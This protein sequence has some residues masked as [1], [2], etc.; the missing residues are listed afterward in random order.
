MDGG[1]LCG[2]GGSGSTVWSRGYGAPGAQAATAVTVD[3]SGKIV[4]VGAINGSIDF[5]CGALMST[6]SSSVFV[7]K[8][9]PSAG[10]VWSKRFDST[11]GSAAA[12][13]AVDASDDILIA[14]SFSGSIDLGGTML[15]GKGTNA[16]VTKLDPSGTP[17]WSESFGNGTAV[18][19]G[20][21]ADGTGNILVIG[22]FEGSIDLG[23][24]TLDGGGS[25]F[26]AKLDPNGVPM[27]G[28]SSGPTGVADASGVAVDASGSVLVTGV[29]GPS[30]IDFGC[31]MVTLTGDNNPFVVKLNPNGT[32]SWSKAFKG[33][34]SAYGTSVAVDPSA[35]VIVTGYFGGPGSIDFGGPAPV[36]VNGDTDMFVAKFAPDGGYQWGKGF[37]TIGATLGYAVA[38]DGEGAIFAAGSLNGSADFGSV[39]L[40]SEGGDNLMIAS[41]DAAGN[42]RWARRFAGPQS[43]P[44]V[45]IAVDPF[46]HVVVAGGFADFLDFGCG[47]LVSAGS[48][49]VFVA[50]LVR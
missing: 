27:W 33:A 30:P 44:L 22:N 37:G 39:A 40:T 21:A 41:L 8:L 6:A 1:L 43:V 42:S 48:E 16:F 4:L 12:S 46:F 7:A 26:I 31:G 34:T 24:A 38:V 32:C 28:K 25:V 5:G 47:P 36:A 3:A 29:F 17:K 11:G 9:D 23:G 20:V 50:D 10:C 35:Y 13:V 14:G 49:N 15:M 2:Q 45:G 18:G 19:T